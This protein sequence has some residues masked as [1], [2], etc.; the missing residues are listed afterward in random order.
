MEA[1]PLFFFCGLTQNMKLYLLL[2][3]GSQQ[4]KTD[5]DPLP[6]KSAGLKTVIWNFLLWLGLVA[7]V[8]LLFARAL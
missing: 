1:F 6:H 5:L 2:P 8:S 3:V 4:I 7:A